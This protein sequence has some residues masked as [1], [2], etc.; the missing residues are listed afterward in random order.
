[1]KFNLKKILYVKDF[2]YIMS[3][4]IHIFLQLFFAA[5]I[6]QINILLFSWYAG[7]TGFFAAVNKTTTLFI[8]IQFIPGLVASGTL[9]VGSKLFGQ[10]KEKELSKLIT[11]GILINLTITLFVYILTSVFASTF[12]SWLDAKNEFIVTNNKYNQINELDFC[13]KYFQ[14]INIS[15]VIMS[16]VQVLVA[17]LQIIS[18]QRHIAIGSILSNVVDIILVVLVLYA[19]DWN[20]IYASLGLVLA[21]LF[22]LVYMIVI[23]VIYIDYR[24][25]KFINQIEVKY[26]F[27]TIK[28]GLPIT[29]EIG[30]WNV[31]NFVANTAISHLYVNST[32]IDQQQVINTFINLHRTLT[33]IV[34]Y[35]ITFLIAIS[36][37]TSMLVAKMIG[38]NDKQKAFEI[39]I[40]CWKIAIYSQLLLSSITL[41]LT[42][43]LL[44]AFNINTVL[45]NKYG[46]ILMGVLFIKLLFDTAN[47]TLLRALWSTGDLWVP[48]L[49]SVIT[50]ISGMCLLPWLVSLTFKGDTGYGL[51]LIYLVISLDP[52]LR[53]IIY[54]KRW[55]KRKWES[56]VKAV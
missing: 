19:F 36:T 17:G 10:N 55:F 31:C 13:V 14:I 33:A 54:T 37:I 39:G 20:P 18:K 25:W 9:V 28:I 41:V 8:A 7:G 40:D 12:L 1:M 4:T 38:K 5:I 56:R 53:S 27:E 26:M 34:Q 43:P 15:L 52:I 32:F 11:T 6:S 29:L 2:K 22:Q 51:V 23:N 16:V 49:I 47:M 24:N 45:I 35:S 3:L 46:Y 44:K 30:L 21:A 42:Y 50:M 48:L